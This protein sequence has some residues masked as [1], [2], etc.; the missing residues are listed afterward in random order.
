VN[1]ENI[2]N[3]E[4]GRVYL[5]R[6]QINGRMS[7]RIE[8]AL[9]K[10]RWFHEGS[11][12][13]FAGWRLNVKWVLS[14]TETLNLLEVD[15]ATVKELSKRWIAIEIERASQELAAARLKH[16]GLLALKLRHELGMDAAET[17]S[18]D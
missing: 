5:V 14:N 7:N 15:G 12:D 1:F 11:M 8:T 9:I 2:S 13:T 17:A 4:V 16:D 6:R 3:P 10:A 18:T